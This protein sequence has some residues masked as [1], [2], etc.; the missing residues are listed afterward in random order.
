MAL[1]YTVEPRKLSDQE[2][3]P[4]E[5]GE[6]EFYGVYVK[7]IASFWGVGKGEPDAEHLSNHLWDFPD[8]ASAQAFVDRLQANA[9]QIAA[10]DNKEPVTVAGVRYFNSQD[11]T[12]YTA[13]GGLSAGY[14]TPAVSTWEI[15]RYLKTGELSPELAANTIAH[16]ENLAGREPMASL[17][18]FE[19]QALRNFAASTQQDPSF[20]AFRELE[21]EANRRQGA[22]IPEGVNFRTFIID[23][24]PKSLQDFV[25]HP[26]F[27]QEKMTVEQRSS[28]EQRGI[29]S[30]M[31]GLD[32]AGM[33]EGTT[34]L[35]SRADAPDTLRTGVLMHNQETRN[36]QRLDIVNDQGLRERLYTGPDQG[37]EAAHNRLAAVVG[38]VLPT[39]EPLFVAG[40]GADGKIVEKPQDAQSF[41]VFHHNENGEAVP[42]GQAVTAD[43]AEQLKGQIAQGR[44]PAPV[45]NLKTVSTLGQL[46]DLLDL[47]EAKPDLA[48]PVEPKENPDKPKEE[49][50][51]EDKPKEDQPKPQQPQV[52]HQHIGL[53]SSLL[54]HTANMGR[55]VAR[56]IRG[57]D[58]EEWQHRAH[59]HMDRAQAHLDAIAQHPAVQEYQKMERLQGMPDRAKAIYA[60][61]LL[62]NNPD[63]SA[64]YVQASYNVEKAQD[65]MF[66]MNKKN[67]HADP[68]ILEKAGKI[69]QTASKL[70]DMEGGVSGGLFSKLTSFFTAQQSQATLRRA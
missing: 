50:T 22:H 9:P 33:A 56:A 65:A 46:R 7:G 36:G 62:R 30:P 52:V 45:E 3:L 23:D 68:S 42:V 51:K 18:D 59:A 34:L 31:G 60:D 57:P 13:E 17:D 61:T 29:A 54:M 10:L 26:E 20:R 69:H 64:H 19:K 5:P 27:P 24:M 35:Y 15:D 55:G 4:A 43:L 6:A 53:L 37:S 16:L 70:P 49:K 40:V 47:P 44:T 2:V 25:W 66:F 28:G 21:S 11:G 12:H 58:A 14:T 32:M 67:G 41:G 8:Q 1:E 38:Y 63:L 39:T 48:Q